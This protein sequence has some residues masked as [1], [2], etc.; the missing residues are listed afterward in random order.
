MGENTKYAFRQHKHTYATI[1]TMHR[2]AGRH[3]HV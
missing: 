2:Q 3:A 1:H